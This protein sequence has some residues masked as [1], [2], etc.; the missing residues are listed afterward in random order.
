MLIERHIVVLS[1]FLLFPQCMCRKT[2]NER[3]DFQCENI[4]FERQFRLYN[5]FLVDIVFHT[6]CTGA[7]DI[8]LVDFH[9]M[10]RNN[11]YMLIAFACSSS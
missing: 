3:H 4:I 9:F 1:F 5:R 7:V 10:L 2:A 11:H 8:S 6:Q